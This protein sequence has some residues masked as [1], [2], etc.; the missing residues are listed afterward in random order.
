V[1][2]NDENGSLSS[3]QSYS[4]SGN[5]VD[6]SKLV[7]A[8]RVYEKKAKVPVM[9]KTKLTIL[10]YSADKDT[11]NLYSDDQILQSYRTDDLRITIVYRA[12]CFASL[13]DLDR[14]HTPSSYEQLTVEDILETFLNDLE[15]KRVISSDR[16]KTISKFDLADLIMS[17]YIKYPLPSKEAAILP[18][19]YCAVSKVIPW[20][21]PVLSFICR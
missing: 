6:G 19:N 16:R 3:F 12:R 17:T 4:L 7:H 14:Y 1:F 11:W 21:E 8:A 9:D 13:E 10:K 18:H 5:A 20:I 2:Y 15:A